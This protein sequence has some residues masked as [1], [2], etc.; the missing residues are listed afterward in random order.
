MPGLGPGE[1]PFFL[2]DRP[3]TLNSIYRSTR[4][5][6][7]P[8]LA[9]LS[10]RSTSSGSGQL[11]IASL[12]RAL[13]VRLRLPSQGLH[14]E[15]LTRGL[16]LTPTPCLQ[17]GVIEKPR[18]SLFS[19]WRAR[20]NWGHPTGDARLKETRRRMK[21]GKTGLASQT[22]VLGTIPYAKQCSTATLTQSIVGPLE[23]PI[24]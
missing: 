4:F 19:D 21:V 1:W 2:L 15:G 18:P 20:T 8:P 11:R 5:R 3:E 17:P 7:W 16:P 9:H 10:D 14:S 23:P 22:T 12:V 6:P 13:S 24:W